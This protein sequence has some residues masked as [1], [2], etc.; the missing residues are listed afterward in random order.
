VATAQSPLL[1]TLWHAIR[2]HLVVLFA[3]DVRRVD[4]ES[5]LADHLSLRAALLAAGPAEIDRAVTEHIFW[6]AM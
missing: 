6:E 4:P 3:F 2:R 1:A 5:I